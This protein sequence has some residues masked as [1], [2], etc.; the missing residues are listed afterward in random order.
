L[1]SRP[2][3]LF[4]CSLGVHR[5]FGPYIAGLGFRPGRQTR[6]PGNP[7]F[8]LTFTSLFTRHGPPELYGRG[9]ARSANRAI[10]FFSRFFLFL[11]VRTCCVRAPPRVP[12]KI[13]NKPPRPFRTSCWLP[14][15]PP[16]RPPR[17]HVFARCVFFFP[18]AGAS[19][20]FL[21]ALPPSL[22]F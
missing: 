19:A 22:L 21:I 3:F 14:L 5:S 18:E 9:F 7:V 8:F 15:L 1:Q 17:A 2:V 11:R 6:E 4:F 13:V 10:C 20:F 16:F 12:A